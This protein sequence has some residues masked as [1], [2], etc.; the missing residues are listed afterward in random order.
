MKQ[1]EVLISNFEISNKEKELKQRFLNNQR[2]FKKQELKPVISII[3]PPESYLNTFLNEMQNVMKQQTT[4]TIVDELLKS[5]NDFMHQQLDMLQANQKDLHS[6]IQ[7]IA[8]KS[9]RSEDSRQLLAEL[10]APL[11][12]QIFDVKSYYE[13]TKNLAR[14]IGNQ[15]QQMKQNLERGD[16][17]DTLRQT[18]KENMMKFNTTR[19]KFVHK[20]SEAEHLVDKV[21]ESTK[22]DGTLD[23]CTQA[24]L[25]LKHQIEAVGRDTETVENQLENRFKRIMEQCA[26]M[27]N[28]PR[29]L[30]NYGEE[31]KGKIEKVKE[32]LGG[33]FDYFEVF[34]EVEEIRKRRNDIERE[35]KICKLGYPKVS[36]LQE[37]AYKK[38][39]DRYKAGRM[40][41]FMKHAEMQPIR[42]EIQK[43]TLTKKPESLYHLASKPQTPQVAPSKKFKKTLQ[44]RNKPKSILISKPPEISPKP[45]EEFHKKPV[46]IPLPNQSIT[47]QTSFSLPPSPPSEP[48]SIPAPSEPLPFQTKSGYT[49]ESQTHLKPEDLI[50]KEYLPKTVETQ[51][52]PI[53][54]IEQKTVNLVTDFVLAKMLGSDRYIDIEYKGGAARWLGVEEINGLIKEGIYVDPDTIDKLGREVLADEISNLKKRPAIPSVQL[55]DLSPLLKTEEKKPESIKHES[56]EDEYEEDFEES[57]EK[58]MESYTSESRENIQTAVFDR[59][60]PTPNFDNLPKPSKFDRPLDFSRSKI[61][62]DHPTADSTVPNSE[63]SSLLNP[64]MLEMM[65]ATAVQQYVSSLIEAGHIGRNPITDNQIPTSN[66]F[67][68]NTMLET[69]RNISPFNI[70]EL[71]QSKPVL[72]EEFNK[73]FSSELGE[74]LLNLI[75]SNR[76]ASP[77]QILEKF[78]RTY[79]API[80]KG[81]QF[82]KVDYPPE[83]EEKN[84]PPVEEAIFGKSPIESNKLKYGFDLDGEENKLKRE[85]MHPR[86]LVDIPLFKPEEIPSVDIPVAS[87]LSGT[88]SDMMY[89]SGNSSIGSEIF[90]IENPEFIRGF[91][92]FIRKT[93]LEKGQVSNSDL[94]EGE[95]S[96]RDFETLSTGEIQRDDISS[97]G[98]SLSLRTSTNHDRMSVRDLL[99]S[100]DDYEK[101]EGEFNP[102][103]LFNV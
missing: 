47:T 6:L 17:S 52:P 72:P 60:Q 86:R 75:K 50:S 39:Q 9:D 12:R 35:W 95:V 29:D 44:T 62:Q 73:F 51:E 56:F 31:I 25:Y 99:S 13:E 20:I 61:L 93:R 5:Q 94:S 43:K 87:P 14:D 18:V 68:N 49:K 33:D 15:V 83:Y 63:L 82:L 89:S 90:S 78:A 88:D 41:G 84:Q 48:V 80:K 7:T 98:P 8:T 55:I 40:S 19:N 22:D 54:T 42:R 64:R 46:P 77:Q 74:K 26:M 30:M 36:K 34:G 58:P 92:D 103:S 102:A 71:K 57:K 70:S 38:E 69:P 37:V 66:T 45:K 59:N 96:I 100:D 79:L 85:Q 2:N 24:I 27:K 67:F 101:S 3:S 1:N 81:M 23:S 28:L 11:N 65:S 53:H 10:M 97:S 91:M 76:D 21:I 4:G 16:Y 32:Y